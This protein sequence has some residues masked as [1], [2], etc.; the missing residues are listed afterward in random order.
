LD[1]S[2]VVGIVQHMGGGF[3]SKGPIGAEGQLACKLSKQVGAPVKMALA[4]RDEFLMTGNGVGSWQKFRVGAS[5]EGKILAIEIEQY[6]LSG[7]G[8]ARLTDQPYIYHV[9]NVYRQTGTI[10]TN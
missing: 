1:P 2:N 10:H 7:L 6:A 3:G 8:K 5:K 4:R 9:E